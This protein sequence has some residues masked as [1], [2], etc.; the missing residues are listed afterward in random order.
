MQTLYFIPDGTKATCFHQPY[1]PTYS[2]ISRDVAAVFTTLSTITASTH[3]VKIVIVANYPDGCGLPTEE[4]DSQV[5]GLPNSPIVEFERYPYQIDLTPGF[6]LLS[7]ANRLF[8]A[9]LLTMITG[10]K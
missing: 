6:P 7:S 10:S 1:T 3:I 2:A 4:F 9:A 8:G 5:S